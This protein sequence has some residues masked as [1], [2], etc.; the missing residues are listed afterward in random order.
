MDATVVGGRTMFVSIAGRPEALALA[1][2]SVLALA[3]LSALFT[4]CGHAER[5]AEYARLLAE[6]KAATGE[7]R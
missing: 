1:S 4:P 2:A 6:I 5:P 3:L 7:G